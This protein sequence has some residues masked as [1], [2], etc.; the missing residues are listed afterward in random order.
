MKIIA[1]SD[2]HGSKVAFEA[3]AL[4]AEKQKADIILVCG[5]LTNFGTIEQA[6]DLLSALAE[7]DAPL[8]FVPGNCDPPSLTNLN[9]GNIKCIHGKGIIYG[10]IAFIGIGGSPITPFN[11]LFEMSENKIAETLKNC[12]IS[13]KE[14]IGQRKIILVSHS[15]P[16]NT[17][18]DRTTFGIHAGSISVRR[19][20]E[21]HSPLLVV[22]GHIHEARGEDQINGT[23]IINL[24]S[25]KRGE[26]AVI[27]IEEKINVSLRTL[28]I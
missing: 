11:T 19:F 13:L 9:F 26:Y 1:G 24:G 16:K 5:D 22:C 12:L 6:K 7:I 23:L 21:E 8:L 2:F 20:I 15:P 18:L 14:K 27:N 17:K 28:E 4:E 10:K 25:A 3:F